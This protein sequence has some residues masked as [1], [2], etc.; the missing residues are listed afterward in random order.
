MLDAFAAQRTA[1]NA[2]AGLGDGDIPAL[3]RFLEATAGEAGPVAIHA[4]RCGDRVVATLAG[5][6]HGT[7][8]SGMLT[9]FATDPDVARHSPGELLLG[10][11]MKGYCARG[12]TA[13]DLG[14]GEAR[15][16]ATYCPAVELL[17]DSL[18]PL[19]L[20]GR[21]AARAERLRLQAKRAI[22]Q[23]RWAW[24]LAQ[25]IRR[26]LSVLRGRGAPAVPAAVS[27]GASDGAAGHED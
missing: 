11:V 4:L 3:R 24:P 23:S 26:G 21:L 10:E 5:V 14:I 1:R 17:F 9:S 20:R 16:K 12:F 18:V 7:R 27:G 15:Y 19:T 22:K 2:A 25:R 8:F 13:F 6:R